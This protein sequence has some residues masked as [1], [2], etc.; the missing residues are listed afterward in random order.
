MDEVIDVPAWE[1]G[2]GDDRWGEEEEFV[3]PRVCGRSA[4]IPGCPNSNC[5]SRRLIASNSS[6]M[7]VEDRD[8]VVLAG[9]GEM[10]DLIL[11]RLET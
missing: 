7:R 8:S 3:V 2:N 4:T 11:F 9:G 10:G 5:R 6:H 1:G